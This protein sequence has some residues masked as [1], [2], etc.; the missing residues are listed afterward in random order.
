MRLDFANGSLMGS[1]EGGSSSGG[2]KEE[3]GEG[4]DAG[5]PALPQVF[6]FITLKPRV[7]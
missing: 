2:G 1:D 4:G 5:A 7:E 3:S 6:F